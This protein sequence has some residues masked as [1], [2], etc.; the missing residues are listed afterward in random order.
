MLSQRELQTLL[1]LT[2]LSSVPAATVRQRDFRH[3]DLPLG[4]ALLSKRSSSAMSLTAV[5]AQ[6][7][8]AQHSH[9]S[10]PP[11][12][13]QQRNAEFA[14]RARHELPAA[15]SVSEELFLQ[16]VLPYQHFDEPVDDWRPA[17]FEKLTSVPGVRNAATIKELAET[18]IPLAFTHLGNQVTFMSNMTP[19]VMAPISETL[20]AGH[21]SCTGLSIL[22]ANALRSV[23]VPARV[24]GI[25]EWNRPDGGNH[26]WVEVWTGNA[27]Q[28]LDAA[29]TSKVTWDQAW[30]AQDG[31]VQRSLAQG[32]H[33][34]YSPVW[35]SSQ[36]DANYTVTW[37]EPAVMM[38]AVDR[39]AFYKNIESPS[40]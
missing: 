6:D 32:I 1:C 35:D 17:F 30:F 3:R 26:N 22:V 34:V 38:P 9:R 21:A 13:Y 4:K 37:R 36:A 24:A 11:Q 14:M 40:V 16:E 18:V 20:H 5:G 15:A 12:D 2:I 8:L 25:A 33:G 7:W 31:T 23:G 29:P 39:T 19:Q 27:W 28:F 10:A